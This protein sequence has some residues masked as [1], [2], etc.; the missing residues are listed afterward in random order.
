MDNIKESLCHFEHTSEASQRLLLKCEVPVSPNDKAFLIAECKSELKV[1][2][3]ELRIIETKNVK[4]PKT[5]YLLLYSLL[6]HGAHMGF[7]TISVNVDDF[8]ELGKEIFKKSGFIHLLPGSPF[9]QR[10]VR[11]YR[12]CGIGYDIHPLKEGRKLVLAGVEIDSRVGLSGHSD[13]DVLTH[14]VIDAILGAA[15]LGDIGQHFP[16]TEEYRNARSLELL[17]NLVEKLLSEAILIEH[18]D[19]TLIIDGVKLSPLRGLM[20]KNIEQV[21]KAPASIKFKTGNGI[22]GKEYAEAY[23]VAEIAFLKSAFSTSYSGDM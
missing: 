6:L 19:V 10:G 22:K 11:L 15:G 8:L 1:P 12:S 4:E 14:A 2:G 16:E 5:F 17:S 7:C 20:L 18:V 3:A 23:A 13:A 21:L 9:M